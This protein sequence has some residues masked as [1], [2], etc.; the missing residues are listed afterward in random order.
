MTRFIT[1]KACC[2]ISGKMRTEM[3]ELL[4]STSERL[5]IIY[6]VPDQFESETEKAVYRILDKRGLTARSSEV[7]IRT[8]SSLSEEILSTLNEK[9]RPADEIVKNIVMHRVIKEN[10]NSLRALGCIAEKP[11][12]CHKMVQTI[13]MLKTA[14]ITAEDLS[15]DNIELKLSEAECKPSDGRKDIQRYT[16]V[17]DKL[18]DVGVLY[19]AYNAKLSEH[20]LDKLDYT[21]RAAEL[22]ADTDIDTFDNAY[23][24]ID[25]FNDFTN[26][27][28]QFLYNVVTYADNVTMGFATE[29]D[30]YTEASRPELFYTVNRQISRLKHEAELNGTAEVCTEGLSERLPRNSAVRFL[31]DNIYG[32]A[33]PSDRAAPELI[34][35]KDIYEELDYVAA[36]IKQ[37]T[38]E[39]GMKYSDIAV[40]CADP[41][42]YRSYVDSAFGKY[43]IPIFR[44]IPEPILHQPLVNFVMA[45]L[46][47]V[48]EFS[49]ETV[50]SY[51]KTDFLQ[52]EVIHDGV[53]R[54]IGLTKK[55][56]DV[57]ETYIYEWAIGSENLKKEFVF[58]DKNT[59]KAEEIRRAVAEPILELRTALKDK[60]GEKITEQIFDFIINR[61][62]IQR[63][64]ASR[65][66][67]PDGRNDAVL[68]N[69]YQQLWDTLS[70]IFDSL[71]HGLEGDKI[72]LAD[73]TRLFRD[74]CSETSLAKPPQY[75]DTVL[76]GDIDRTRVGDVKAV[77]IIGTLYDTFPSPVSAEGVFSEFET[78]LIRENIVHVDAIHKKEYSLKSAKEQYCLSL[79]RVY[80]AVSLPSELLCIT[81]PQTDLSGRKVQRSDIFDEVLRLFKNA[82]VRSAAEFGD[83]FYCR[84]VKA[85]KQRYAAGIYSDS[86]F[87]SSLRAALEQSGQSDYVEQLHRLKDKRRNG[88]SQKLKPQTSDR[89]FS[90]NIS[91]TSMESLN[92][93]RFM[94]FCKNG[95]RVRETVQRTFN[96]INRGNA[97]HYVMQKVLERYCNDMEQFFKLDRKAIAQLVNH[98][99]T[100]YRMTEMCGDFSGDKRVE[101]LYNN[102]AV[103][104]CDVL[105]VLQAEFA[106]RYYRPKLF[107]LNLT[108]GHEKEIIGGEKLFD[109][110]LPEAVLSTDNSNSAEM[111]AQADSNQSVDSEGKLY[112]S[113]L[114]IATDKHLINITGMIDRVDMFTDSRGQKYL[115]VVD[116]K[117]NTRQFSVYNAG[118]GINVQMLLYLFALCDA[119]SE[120][121]NTILPGGVSYTPAKI[122]GAVN[123][124]LSAFNLLSL[125]HR[126]SG[127]Y[128][129]DN[130]TQEEMEHYAR[131]IV[132]KIAGESDNTA[133]LSDFLPDEDNL[134]SSEDFAKFRENCL[135]T[136][137]SKLN[138]LFDGSIDA[139]PL[140]YTE[141]GKKAD[142]S[143]FKHDKCGCDYCQFKDICGN[144]GVKDIVPDE[145][146]AKKAAKKEVE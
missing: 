10:K 62:G 88:Q 60:S 30:T 48:K 4:E 127:M 46:N 124:R 6:I 81:C 120:P 75:V 99:L 18:R 68:M 21:S 35:A 28:M 104:A 11:G 135:S 111:P 37:L 83:V 82:R 14:G 15:E 39:C 61:V 89:L 117:T 40:L 125:N 85:A 114:T 126:Q 78:E 69:A 136:M 76:V 34:N 106:A 116:Y 73:Y 36:R 97:V 1:G 74:I 53:V 56:I 144:N 107:E 92:L 20:Y 67:T 16:L 7:N 109:G 9:K 102:I 42:V 86:V 134:L 54:K 44:D 119:N 41:T 47:V 130:S 72:T 87:Q 131:F 65:C 142:G 33:S 143:A 38:T 8:F 129:L 17:T 12:F 98:Y 22:I 5:K 80:R 123:S 77:F 49:V 45:L 58:N 52:R 105:I 133:E 19:L 13:T 23:V 91:A 115:R 79:Y 146:E 43:D 27:Q 113:P 84:S 121:D 108:E 55:D 103:A 122:S 132:D 110:V 2:D 94:Y 29:Y 3:A 95:L 70:G 66:K 50:L 90:K 118:Y 71:W 145:K 141:R 59:A 96:S 26:S 139:L 24:F 100:E 137:R 63:A 112:I 32:G 57:F 138:L 31:S 140:A 101:Y 51:V 25:C 64:I 93:C 128:V